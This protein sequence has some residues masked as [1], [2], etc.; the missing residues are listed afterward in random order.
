M[1][2]FYATK[3]IKTQLNDISTIFIVASGKLNAI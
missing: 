2:K 1:V 3:E